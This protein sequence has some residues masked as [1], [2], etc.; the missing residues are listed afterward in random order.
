MAKKEMVFEAAIERLEEIVSMLESGDFPLDKSLEL[1]EEG[2][3]LVKE[4]NKKLNSVEKSVK[5]LT[6]GDTEL[7][8]K[9]FI[10]NEE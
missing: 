5:I 9:D 1:F 10:T 6:Q 2:T 4:C 8:E 3:T 7:I